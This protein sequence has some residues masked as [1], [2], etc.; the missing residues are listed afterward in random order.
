MPE[1]VQVIFCPLAIIG[2]ADLG[3]N[4]IGTAGSSKSGG[5]GKAAKFDGYFLRALDF[6]YRM[7]QGRIADERFI[8]RVK[9]D[10]SLMGLGEIDPLGQGF[11]ADC[12]SG[13]VVWKTKIYKVNRFCG[14]GRQKVIVR[15]AGHIDNA[16]V[17]AV[18]IDTGASRHHIGIKIDWIDRIGYGDFNVGGKKLL[19]IGG[20]AFRSVADEN[21]TGIDVGIAGLKVVRGNFFPQE[22]IP[23]FR[24]VAFK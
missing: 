20:I 19:D 18:L 11:T 13:R 14:E 24:S 6:I 15:G 9:K 7:R 3:D 12:R 21:F 8:G 17:A 16:T 23:L 10:E 1:G 2:A 22:G 5:L 4:G